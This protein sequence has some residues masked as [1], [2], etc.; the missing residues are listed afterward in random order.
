MSYFEQEPTGANHAGMLGSFSVPANQ[1]GIPRV[2]Y[3]EIGNT[4]SI[5]T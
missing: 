4:R 3:A 2:S 5:E 1:M